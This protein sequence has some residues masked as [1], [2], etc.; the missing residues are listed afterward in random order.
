[1]SNS[2]YFKDIRDIDIKSTKVDS[3]YFDRMVVKYRK[4][5]VALGT[6]VTQ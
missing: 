1:M 4:E 2:K 5:I 3:Y 6:T